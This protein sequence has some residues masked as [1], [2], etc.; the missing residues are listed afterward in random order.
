VPERLTGCNAIVS[1][2][3][4]GIG[5]AVAAK[6]VADGAKVLLVD[7]DAEHGSMTAADLGC[8]FRAMDVTREADWEQL[9]AGRVDIL[10]NNAGGLL[11]AAV[12]HEH[13]L[14]SW[15]ATLELN[16]TSV[17]LGMRY[18]LPQML[19]RRSGT[20]VNVASVSGLTAQQD[21]PAYQA[22]K[23]GVAMLTRNAALTYGSQGVRVNAVSPSVVAT[24]ALND[25]PPERLERFL[26]RVPVGHA[27]DPEDI[28]NA[29]AFLASDEAR[30]VTGAILAVDGGYLA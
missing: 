20:I 7:V 21:A 5:R 11:N 13:D 1:G 24:P 3:A 28:A 15:R 18:V 9:E 29:V 23:A 4:R 8:A 14:E 16:L 27:G 12:I 26:A 17:F 6:F 2:G 30:Y 22:A 25:E 10:V 19:A